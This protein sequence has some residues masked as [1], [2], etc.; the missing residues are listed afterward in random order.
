M[1]LSQ[2]KS[3]EEKGLKLFQRLLVVFKLSI[4]I[5]P[6]KAR[7]EARRHCLSRINTP[8]A[9][10][11]PP[12]SKQVDYLGRH[13]PREPKAFWKKKSTWREQPYN[14][15]EG[16]PQTPPCLLHI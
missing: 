9:T 4:I 3:I 8:S 10:G 16:D 6:S 1:Q 13:N 11:S 2:E 15:E 14:G 12:T 7:Q 5:F